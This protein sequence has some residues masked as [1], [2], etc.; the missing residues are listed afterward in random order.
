M[1]HCTAQN[2]A[3]KQY[4]TIELL[5]EYKDDGDLPLSLA[6]ITI[7]S[8]MRTALGGLVD[9]LDIT[10]LDVEAGLFV[11]KPTIDKLPTGVLSI[12]VLFENGGKRV[13]SDTF[14]IEV[15]RSITNPFIG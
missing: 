13:A 11:M 12:D 15:N 10:V 14:T 2:K 3:I 7:K 9:N 5:C 8:D 4:S 6:G 1:R